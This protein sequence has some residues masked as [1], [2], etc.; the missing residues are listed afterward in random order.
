MCIVS[1][2]VLL[3]FFAKIASPAVQQS[4]SKIDLRQKKK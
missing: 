1:T 3:F 4:Q 2:H